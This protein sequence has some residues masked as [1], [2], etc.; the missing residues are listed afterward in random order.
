MLT[1]KLQDHTVTTIEEAAREQ[2]SGSGFT[3]AA[4]ILLLAILPGLAHAVD[5]LTYH[6]DN[7]RTG[8]NL[9]E[10][11]LTPANVNSSQF[12]LLR[13]LAADGKVYFLSRAGKCTVMAAKPTFEKLAS[14]EL[15]DETTATPAV[16]DGRIYLRGKKV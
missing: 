15:D 7:G 8:Q 2:R 9:N 6:N 13:V 16:A 14:N 5:V 1:I 4:C 11:L 12:G 3:R 10:T